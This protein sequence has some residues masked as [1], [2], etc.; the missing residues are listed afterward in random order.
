MNNPRL[1]SRYAKSLIDIAVEKGELETVYAD[2]KL[3]LGLQKTNPDFTAM[4]LSPIISSDKKEKILEAIIGPHIST[5]TRLFNQLLVRK[6]REKNLPEIVKA[7]IDQYN[8]IKGIHKAKLVTAGEVSDDMKQFI[9]NKIKTEAQVAHIELESEVNESLLGGFT[10]QMEDMFIDASISR[11][12]YDIRRQF[13]SNEY[14]H[15]IR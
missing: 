13:M 15:R 5:L 6:G 12:L 7:Y 9:I 2:M 4:L 10:L 3:L 1:A 8:E 14:I 11:D